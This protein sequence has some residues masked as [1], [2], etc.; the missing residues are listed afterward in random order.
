MRKELI[1]PAV[2]AAG[3]AAGFAQRRWGLTAGF[4]AD[5]GL[6]VLGSPSTMALI[7]FSV[8]MAA[9]LL[10]LVQQKPHALAEGVPAFASKGNTLYA[11][12]TVLAAFLMLASAVMNVWLFFTREITALTRLVLAA[13]CVAAFA[14]IL[15]TAQRNLRGE[16]L[17]KYS[18]P[19]LMPAYAC[20]MWL[21]TAY[22]ARAA[23]PVILDYVYELFAVVAVLLALYFTA[24]FSFERPKV[25][26][27]S[28]FSLLGVYFSIVTLADAHDL[29]TLLLYAFAILYLLANTAVL[30]ANVRR[31]PPVPRSGPEPEPTE[32]ESE[33]LPDEP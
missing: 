3:G 30:L 29:P 11:V 23:D 28:F 21:V 22:Q 19:Q 27:A 33:V 15:I 12:V 10:L 25:R 16:A 31:R 2:A 14:C 17:V 7:A 4:E 32:T 18:L 26:R 5:T 8:V 9:V 20:C 13:L 24:G 6:P 1:L